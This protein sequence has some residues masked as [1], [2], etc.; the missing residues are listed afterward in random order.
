MKERILL[1]D[2]EKEI[3]DLMEIYLKND[4][5]TV[6]KFY[7]GMEALKCIAS[8]K[9]DLAVLDVMLPDIDGFHI[10]RKIREQYFFPIIMLTAKMEDAD[11]IMGLTIGADDYITKPFN[12]LEVAA[13]VKTQLRR[14]KRYNTQSVQQAESASEYDIKGLLIN[15]DTHSCRLFGENISLTPTEF[16]ILWYLCEHQ[17]KVVS[18][19]ELFEAVWK[20][21]YLDNNNTIMAHIGRL[22]EK[23]HEPAKK[24]RFIRT[25]WGV[26]YRIDA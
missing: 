13:R 11:K 3:A 20:E 14:Y 26:G 18:S 25:V 10:C 17:G 1:V 19:E 12:P 6:Y 21:K 23:L 16:S 15:R 24:P 5:Y 7:S 9:V 4:G 2:D 22:R 8:Q